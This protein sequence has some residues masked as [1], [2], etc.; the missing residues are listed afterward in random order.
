MY[1]HR[2]ERRRFPIVSIALIAA[3]VLLA[4]SSS[5]RSMIK[6][7]AR[8]GGLY[9]TDLSNWMMSRKQKDINE[10]GSNM[11][12]GEEEHRYITLESGK[13]S[14]AEQAVE[15]IKEILEN[16]ADDTGVQK[17]IKY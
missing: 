4:T 3:G 6:Q 9:L 15:D 11:G 1:F 16:E 2:N 14:L 13:E 12:E 17:T 5:A 7:M 8:K 10:I